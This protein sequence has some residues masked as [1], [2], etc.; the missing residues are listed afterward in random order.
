E[1]CNASGTACAA[2]AGANGMKYAVTP[3]DVGSTLRVRETAENADGIGSPAQSAAR[4]VVSAK[5]PKL[6]SLTPGSGITGSAV[7]INGSGLGA[8][9]AVAFG[10]LAAQFKVLS[11][12]QIEAFV[13]AGARAGKLSVTAPAG[14]AQSKAKFTPT[15]SV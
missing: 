14:S 9:T 12:S 10:A 13:P 15:L 2:I 6:A 8:V 7:T 11:A 3:G 4:G 5:V 1:R